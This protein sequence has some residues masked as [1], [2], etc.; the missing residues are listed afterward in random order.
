ML[1]PRQLLIL[2]VIVDDFIDT[3]SPVGS[4]TLSKKEEITFSSAT[5]RNEMADLEEQGYI[6]KTHSSSG[7]IPSQKG[8]RFYVDHLLQPDHVNGEDVMRLQNLFQ[9][10]M[11]EKE[12]IIQDTSRILSE[13]TNYTSF[14]LGP[15]VS[16]EKLQRISIVPLN[17]TTLVAIV[18]TDKGQVLN[19]TMTLTSPVNM[20]DIEKTVNI[21]NARIVGVP[22]SQFQEKLIV[23]IA[24]LLKQ[25]VE[26][27]DNMYT[28]LQNAINVSLM[29]KVYST[30]K[31]KILSQPEFHDI[32]KIKP[33]LHMIE[34]E[35][36]MLTLLSGVNS[37]IEIRIGSENKMDELLDCSLITAQF[38]NE[39]MDIGTLAIL[40][41][42][43][44]DYGRVISLLEA[45][46]TS[47]D[48]LIQT[49]PKKE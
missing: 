38:K 9:N 39:H 31:S 25:H 24:S 19:K 44:M 41:P 33:I 36:Q 28:I 34:S 2:Q 8:Y 23:E 21:L 17:E 27:F 13:L 46:H 37:G 11:Y 22:L 47:I 16:E 4:R 45:V 30:G 42:T 35:N 26:D 15:T 6:E 18:V 48:H 20:S 3:G 32:E 5:I 12:L 14:V 29:P 40:G 49:L 7:R 43:R 1:T 10:K